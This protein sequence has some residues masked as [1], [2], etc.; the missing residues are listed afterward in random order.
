M[1]KTI[2]ELSDVELK[3]AAYDN[4]AQIETCQENLKAINIE[5]QS[6]PKTETEK[7]HED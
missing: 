5:L 7:P 3:A 1:N 6:R 2:K 4:L